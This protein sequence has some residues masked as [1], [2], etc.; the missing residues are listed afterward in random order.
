MGAVFTSEGSVELQRINATQTRADTAHNQPSKVVRARQYLAIHHEEP[1]KTD[2]LDLWDRNLAVKSLLPH[3][4]QFDWPAAPEI[5]A[6]QQ[7]L[8]ADLKAALT[9]KEACEPGTTL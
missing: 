6:A 3:L 7:N 5:A 4:E 9:P 8:S 1:E 2:D